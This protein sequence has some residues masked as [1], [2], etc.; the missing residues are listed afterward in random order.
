MPAGHNKWSKIKHKKKATDLEK[1]KNIQKYMT[2]IV[3]AMKTGGGP[4]PDVNVRLAS[5]IETARKAGIYDKHHYI[6]V[7]LMQQ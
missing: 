4:D 2:L 1:S 7:D 5:V 3:S 6:V